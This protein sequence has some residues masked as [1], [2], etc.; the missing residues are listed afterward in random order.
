[1]ITGR[2]SMQRNSIAKVFGLALVLALALA[3]LAGLALA[4]HADGDPFDDGGPFAASSVVPT[5]GE[6]SLGQQ[7]GFA[8]RVVNSGSVTAGDVLMW[9]PLPEGAT[10]VSASGGAFPVVG[11]TLD[12]VVL[13]APREGQAYHA[14][15]QTS[16]PLTGPDQVTGV[17][18]VGAGGG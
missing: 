8:V 17:A 15:L 1:M 5:A 4:S 3:A 12:D 6:V 13:A 18:W 16:V 11:G 7:V 2:R 9:N 10:Y 14:Q